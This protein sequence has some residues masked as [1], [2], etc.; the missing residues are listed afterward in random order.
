MAPTLAPCRWAVRT[1]AAAF[2]LAVLLLPAVQAPP[3]AHAAALVVNTLADANPPATGGLCSLREAITNANNNAATHP[4]CPAGVDADTIMFSVSGTIV[5]VAA[6]PDIADPASLTIDGSG[7]AVTVSGNNAVR[8]FTI[9]PA[10]AGEMRRVS[11][12]NG[13]A[14]G[15]AGAS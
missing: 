12:T 4:D 10:G 1:M 15:D 3:P 7:Q 13:Y 14:P 9:V 5:L 11:V 8:V 6:L 2:A